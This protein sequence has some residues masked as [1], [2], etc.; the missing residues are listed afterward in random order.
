LAAG[1]SS[2][3][4]PGSM[5]VAAMKHRFTARS[6]PLASP[7]RSSLRG[8]QLFGRVR[9]HPNASACPQHRV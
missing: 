8:R 4:G 2:A 1:G 9:N 7:I 3:L 5:V 6:V